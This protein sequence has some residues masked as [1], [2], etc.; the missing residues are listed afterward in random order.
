MR[1]AALLILSLILSG[2]AKERC[3]SRMNALEYAQCLEGGGRFDTAELKNRIEAIEAELES[4]G[5]YWIECEGEN[6]ECRLGI[7][8]CMEHNGKMYWRST[9]TDDFNKT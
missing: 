4:P 7:S 3:Y 1:I 5:K 9:Q 6:C 2:C 8:E